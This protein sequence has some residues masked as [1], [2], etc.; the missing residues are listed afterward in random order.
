MNNL[1]KAATL[2]SALAIFDVSIAAASNTV[3]VNTTFDPNQKGQVC[4][5]SN[6]QQTVE[7]IEAGKIK[8]DDNPPLPID[9]PSHYPKVIIMNY[10]GLETSITTESLKALKNLLEEFESLNLFPEGFADQLVIV[11]GAERGGQA[12]QRDITGR[13]QGFVTTVMVDQ[14][15][16][17]A[18][19]S[20]NKIEILSS[21]DTSAHENYHIKQYKTD[22]PLLEQILGDKAQPMREPFANMF[23]LAVQIELAKEG[24]FMLPSPEEIIKKNA[25]KSSWGLSFPGKYRQ[26]IVKDNQ[27]YEFIHLVGDTY[28]IGDLIFLM[29]NK[30]FKT[31]SPEDVVRLEKSL[32]GLN[33]NEKLS[34]KT[35]FEKMMSWYFRG[36]G[37]PTLSYEQF[38]SMGLKEIVD[39]SNMKIIDLH[40]NV[41]TGLKFEKV[42]T[43]WLVPSEMY[44]ILNISS[45]LTSDADLKVIFLNDADFKVTIIKKGQPLPQ[46]KLILFPQVDEKLQELMLNLYPINEF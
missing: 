14:I 26:V 8:L 46:G 25:V 38:V 9:W 22:G 28:T 42:Y 45:P 23:S 3:Q 30:Y 44:A 10:C 43:T 12:F 6:K 24:K 16:L 11:N 4:E 1:T 29:S 21:L 31:L 34:F 19:L 15:D 36:Q 39:L 35:I 2:L 17:E 7:L 27:T 18:L 37:L 5:D 20:N 32:L 13:R 41:I 40:E 33:I